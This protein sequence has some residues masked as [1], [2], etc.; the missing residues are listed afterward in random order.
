MG[1]C[2]SYLTHQIS[3]IA[4]WQIHMKDQTKVNLKNRQQFSIFHSRQIKDTQ[5]FLWWLSKKTANPNTKMKMGIL[6]AVLL[7]ISLKYIQAVLIS[8]PFR[9][10]NCALWKLIM[11]SPHLHSSISLCLCCHRYVP[12]TD[13]WIAEVFPS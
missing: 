12:S 8:D 13:L 11:P 9:T 4:R 3:V 6:I 2:C 1:N 10:V 7:Q 5:S